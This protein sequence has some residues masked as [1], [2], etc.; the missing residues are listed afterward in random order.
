MSGRER[1]R[2]NSAERPALQLGPTYQFAD[3]TGDDCGCWAREVTESGS[4]R[5]YRLGAGVVQATYENAYG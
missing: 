3:G 2:G 5:I 4:R 1:A